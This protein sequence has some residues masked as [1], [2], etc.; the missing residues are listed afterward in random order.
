MT[1]D[2]FEAL[3]ARNFETLAREETHLYTVDLDKDQ[4]WETYLNAFPPGTNEIYRTR[5]AFDCSCCRHF[6]KQFGNVVAITS[7]F[8]VVTLWDFDPGDN[9][10]APVVK[11]MA[12]FVRQN[13][14]NN[15][16]VTR[17]HA[18]G[19]EHSLD[20]S[21]TRALTWDHFYLKL[22]RKFIYDGSVSPEEAKGEFRTSRTTLE[23]AIRDISPEA[24]TSVLEMIEEGVVYRGN[25]A[26]SNLK[27]FAHVQETYWMLTSEAQNLYLWREVTHLSGTITRLHN[28]AMGTLLVN[29]SSGVN[30]EEAL[31]QYETIMASANY[32]RP[33]AKFTEK[34]VDQA[35]TKLAAL[36]LLDS[37]PRRFATPSDLTINNVLWANRNAV[38]PSGT[39]DVFAALKD[40]APVDPRRFPPNLP[41]FSIASFLE[42]VL[43]TATSVEVLL[44]N[45]HEGN[46]VSLLA[47]LNSDA[48]PLFVWGDNFSWAYNGNLADSG[49]KARVKAAGGKIDG[50]L[51]FSIQWNEND[52]NK[53]DLDAHCKEP[54]GNE[55]YYRNLL[56]PRTRGNL[57]VDIVH[58]TSQAAVE[59]ITWPDLAKMPNG[60]YDFFVHKF[61]DRFGRNGFRAE[62]E[63]NGEVYTYD[64][65]QHG[66]DTPVATVTKTASGFTIKHHLPVQHD[67]TRELWGLKT[68]RFQPV[69]TVLLSPNYWEGRGYGNK[70]YFFMLAGCENPTEPNGFYNEFLLPALRP[71]RQ[72]LEAL[73]AK[74][75]VASA[76][77]QLSGL[78]FSSTLRNALTVKVNGKL[79]K[80]IF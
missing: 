4:L 40:D 58:P 32:R 29:L 5:R 35:K 76:P 23:R 48:T 26:V 1:F 36:G 53:D 77:H 72:V 12:E 11:A 79:L 45:Q 8:S 38:K 33:Q 52:D 14:V 66:G 15:V 64:C 46:L 30:P 65:R 75:K 78:G 31:R 55:I 71:H 70:H 68:M 50:V 16:L 13:A 57:D 47:P 19:T 43:P 3:F 37:L 22:P 62:I 17:E 69:S 44:E 42:D 28:T 24:I 56:N 10:Y 63:F 51:R 18:F 6:I 21:G 7:D 80:I 9:V 59:N 61:S 49:M 25:E 60:N 20:L 34:M 39:L 41:A 74:L 2:K 54:D 67:S 73:S 27:K